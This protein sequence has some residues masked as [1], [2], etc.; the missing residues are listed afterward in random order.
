MIS[1]LPRTLQLRTL[2]SPPPPTWRKV[3]RRWE[4]FAEAEGEAGR[5]GWGA[6]WRRAADLA[7]EEVAAPSGWGGAWKGERW[8]R[9]V[10]AG[11]GGGARWKGER[12]RRAVEAGRGGGD[13]ARVFFGVFFFGAQNIGGFFYFLPELSPR[14]ILAVESRSDGRSI[15][16]RW[17]IIKF[18]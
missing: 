14:S 11:G 8:Q 2:N 10:D 4:D 1:F 7:K 12:W 3:W 18:S 15:A 9:T 6:R 16:D 13:L 17:I 5:G